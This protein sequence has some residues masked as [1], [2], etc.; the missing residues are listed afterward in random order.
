MQRGVPRTKYPNAGTWAE[1]ERE[2]SENRKLRHPN[3]LRV[4]EMLE[5]RESPVLVTPLGRRSLAQRLRGPLRVR[6]ALRLERQLLLALS[7]AHRE[8]VLHCDVKP[9]NLLLMPS[10]RL[11]LSDFGSARRG[12]RTVVGDG[13]GTKGYM[14]PEQVAFRP[15]ARSDVYAAGVV[16]KEMLFGAPSEWAQARPRRGVPSAVLKLI[17]K[18]MDDDPARRYPDAAAMLVDLRKVER[19]LAARHRERAAI[20]ESRQAR[21][22]ARE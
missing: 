22:V 3:I 4:L 2:F 16:L 18:A 17:R 11:V 12:L 5:V 10:G 20:L 21:P 9:D 13:V 8:H 14:A 6:E 15:S 7:H 19:M 1:F